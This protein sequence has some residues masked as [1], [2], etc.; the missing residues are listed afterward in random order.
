MNE[1]NHFIDNLRWMAL[2]LLFPFHSFIIYNNFG[3]GNYIKGPENAILSNFTS[4]LWP[5]FMPL[6]FVIAGISSM[7]ALKKRTIKEYFIERIKKLFLPLI[8]GILIICPFLTYFG[9]LFHNKYNGSYFSQYISFFTK[10]TDLTGYKGGFTPAHL[11]FL[12]Y[13]LIISIIAIPFICYIPKKVNLLIERMNIL[14]LIPLFIIPYLGHFIVNIGGRSVGELFCYFILGYYI[15]SNDNIINKLSKYRWVFGIISITSLP[16]Y[17]FF[18]NGVLTSII[19]RLYGYCFICFIIGIGKEKLNF[20]N[21]MTEYFSNMSFVIYLFHLPWIIII[22][23][24]IM[25]YIQNIYLQAM[26]IT[27]LSIPLTIM[28]VEI[29]RRINITRFMFCL[30][31]VEK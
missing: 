22:A 9:E 24:Y 7:Y 4:V 20:Q 26:I 16:F 5:W 13:L 21:K 30:K 31:K 10:E 27:F 23:Y 28:I 8:F 2:F 11:W 18:T 12:L 17:L 1:R 19:Q 6:L 25:K 15:F 3:E 14:T 29:L